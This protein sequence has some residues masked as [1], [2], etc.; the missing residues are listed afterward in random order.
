MHP[1]EVVST[2]LAMAA[3]ADPNTTS[4][5]PVWA[6]MIWMGLLFALIYFLLIRP[7]N[8]KLKEHENLVKGVKSGDKVI[9]AGGIIGTISNTTDTTLVVKIAENV[10]IEVQRASLVAVIKKAE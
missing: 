9:V 2:I 5:Q 8:V 4:T 1:I 7:Q 10:K 3:P 6:P